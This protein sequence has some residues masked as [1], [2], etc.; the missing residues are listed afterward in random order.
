MVAGP[1]GNGSAAPVKI[2]FK[3]LVAYSTLQ[4][5]LAM[6]ALPIVLNVSKFYGEVIQFSLYTMGLIFIFTR[7]VDA[8]QDPLIGLISDRFTRR[9]P[10]GRLAFVAMMLPV[11]CAGFY[12]LFV[13]PASIVS[14]QVWIA[15]WLMASLLLVHIGYSGVSIR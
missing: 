5:P 11:L 10:K 2:P 12:M 14:S 15:T 4:L 9:G 1:T 13:P 7:L 3:R 6:T 8:V